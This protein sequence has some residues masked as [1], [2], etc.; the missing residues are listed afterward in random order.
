MIS[1]GMRIAIKCDNCS[2]V[3]LDFARITEGIII[4]LF[5]VKV[6]SWVCRCEQVIL[7]V[8]SE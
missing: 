8:N 2:W 6:V 7:S 5:R 1:D 4:S 3:V